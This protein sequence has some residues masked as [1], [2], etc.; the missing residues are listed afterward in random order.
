MENY[1]IVTD[2][3]PA[4]GVTDA[5][6]GIQ[7]LIDENP[8]R[9]LFFPDGVY[10]LRSPIF[11][12]ADPEK[13]VD[14]RLSNYA[15]LTAADG[16]PG[17]AL[18]RLG[19]K[20][21]FN[22]ITIPG[23]NYG[24]TGGVLDCRGIADGISIESGRETKIT[25]TAIK[26]SV[27]GIHVCYGANSGSSDADI[28]DVNITGTCRPDSVGILVEGY[29]NTF[30]NMRIGGVQ[31]GVIIRSGGNM[32]RNIHPLYY[33]DWSDFPSSVG[34][35]DERGTNWYDYCYSDQFCTG[36]VTTAERS[37][38][39]DNCFA[40]WWTSKGKKAC[41][42]RAEGPFNSLV[43]NIRV[44]FR[45]DTE[46]VL[47]SAPAGGSGVLQNPMTQE[48]LLADRAYLPYLQG[49]CLL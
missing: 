49:K 6:P 39:Y 14:L 44:D 22:N 1:L 2:T 18:V 33:G 13:S 4:D 11:T 43:K 15:V 21:P 41:A 36:F 12:P 37:G 24:L 3:V 25:G 10:L 26:S 35:R 40:M 8:H 34:F 23:S 29:D 42:F 17:G 5:A 48:H 16:F 28:R 31:T 45:E 20:D 47:L 46:N 9:T 19:G 27:C 38:V 7:K 32:L 30:T